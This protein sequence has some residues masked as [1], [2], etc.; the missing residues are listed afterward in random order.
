MQ[1][2]PRPEPSCCVCVCDKPITNP[3]HTDTT[4]NRN[5]RPNFK[6]KIKK[7]KKIKNQ[8]E[9]KNSPNE[10]KLQPISNVRLLF[11]SPPAWSPSAA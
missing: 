3:T 5:P 1:S 7:I 2:L 8:K 9:E 4:P 6:K 10:S 11:F